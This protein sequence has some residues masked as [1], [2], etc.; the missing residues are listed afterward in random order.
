MLKIQ[1]L[2]I[3]YF[4]LSALL[5]ITVNA[6]P[7]ENQVDTSGYLPLF[8]EGSLEYNLMLASALGIP[9]EIDRLIKKGADIEAET[10]E[11]A[12]PLIIAVAANKIESVNTLLKYNPEVNKKTSLDET[13][14]L[15]AVKNQNSAIAEALIRAGA[16]VNMP[17][18]HG[19]TPLHYASAY[20]YFQMADLLLYYDAVV[21]KKSVD[22]TTPLM[23]AIWAGNANIADLLIQ[24]GANM[25]ARDSEG[26]TP[27]LIAAQNGDTL[28]M[29]FLFSNGVDPFE[30]NIYNYDALAVSIRANQPNSA[31]YLLN[32][33]PDWSK[34]NKNAVNPYIVASKYRRNDIIGILRASKVPGN[35][36]YSFDQAEFS[37]SSKFSFSDYFTGF[38]FSLREPVLSGG[39]LA[40]L[41]T[42][43]WY[44]RVMIKENDNLIYQYFDRRSMAYAGVFR[45]FALTDDI[46]RPN[47]ILFASLSAAYTF[48]NTFKGTLKVPENKFSILPAISVRLIT[49]NLAFSAG[50]E[51][52][53][54]GFY[55]NG[56]LWL[57]AGASWNFYFD[58]IRGPV[59]TIKW[60]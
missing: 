26:F 24:N 19:A 31:I 35:I 17:D 32:K 13:P 14:L 7:Q 8:Y 40:G 48:G 42:K 54:S 39:I 2:P 57:R 55:K 22:G 28:L 16:D 18:N 60:Y 10:E 23:A 50:I 27:F 49:K 58:N 41:D 56:P 20:G 11:G 52:M 53:K 30:T 46:L 29:D 47:L 21:D 5:F 33:N 15:I 34:R 38:S 59:K 37:L 36:S 1:G 6:S 45:D 3:K 4:I 51:Y 44:T 12:T 9:S 43:L 25:E